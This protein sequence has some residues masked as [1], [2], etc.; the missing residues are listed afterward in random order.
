VKIIER[1]G[2]AAQQELAQDAD[3]LVL[4]MDIPRLDDVQ[5]GLVP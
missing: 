5:P 4:E 1:E 2:A 3:F